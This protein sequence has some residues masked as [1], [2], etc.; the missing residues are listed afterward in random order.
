MDESVYYIEAVFSDTKR[1]L[2]IQT[3]SYE[4]LTSYLDFKPVPC[5]ENHF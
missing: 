3:N 2:N 1:K 5:S 4:F